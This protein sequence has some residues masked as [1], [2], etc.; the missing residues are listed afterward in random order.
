MAIVTLVDRAY[1]EIDVA[2]ANSEVFVFKDQTSGV[3]RCL[4][5]NNGKIEMA[6]VDDDTDVLVFSPDV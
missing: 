4:C 6:N 3:R 5:L 2:D 1:K